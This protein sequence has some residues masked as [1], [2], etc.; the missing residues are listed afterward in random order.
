MLHDQS[1]SCY[2][3]EEALLRPL[4]RVIYLKIFLNMY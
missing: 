2:I 3:L 4:H 1:V